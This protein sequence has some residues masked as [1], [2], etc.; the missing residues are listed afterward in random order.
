MPYIYGPEYVSHEFYLCLQKIYKAYTKKTDYQSDLISMFGFESLTNAYYKCIKPGGIK[1]ESFKD[2]VIR[3]R[4]VPNLKLGEGYQNTPN[5]YI[6]FKTVI[7]LI[8]NNFPCV[9]LPPSMPEGYKEKPLNGFVELLLHSCGVQTDDYMATNK[10]SLL[11]SPIPYESLNGWDTVP[12][13][14]RGE[15]LIPINK[16]GSERIVCNGDCYARESVVKKLID[17]ASLLPSDCQLFVIDAYRPYVRQKVYFERYYSF[18]KEKYLGVNEEELKLL[19]SQKVALPSESVKNPSPHSTGGAIDVTIL[20]KNEK[21]DM[22]WKG[23]YSEIDETAY[24]EKK[25]FQNDYTFDNFRN[26]RRIVENRRLLYNTMTSVGFAGNPFEYWHY[27]YGDQRWGL[28]EQTDAIYG[29]Y[30]R[31]D[32][33]Q[34]SK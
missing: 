22:G 25:I 24:F 28:K 34:M 33:W 14:G 3:C 26:L 16:C 15:Q 32:L 18:L 1:F 10:S 5:D 12:I 23:A 29:Y 2:A 4:Y 30:A 31:H 9:S 19:A 13:E 6:A 11:T 17:A 8:K 7:D 21:I 20:Q 27:S